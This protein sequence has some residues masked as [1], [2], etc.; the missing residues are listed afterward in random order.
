VDGIRRS[1]FVIVDVSEATPNVYYELGLAD[2][3]DKLHVVTAYIDTV[4]PFDVHDVP[5]V[6]WA[7][8]KQLK[9]GLKDRIRKIASLHGR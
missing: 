9:E 7:N 5:T 3:L 6:F 4:L 1:A 8:Q 2:G